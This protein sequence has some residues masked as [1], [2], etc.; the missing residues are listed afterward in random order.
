M[1]IILPNYAIYAINQ[2]VII[3]HNGQEMKWTTSPFSKSNFEDDRAMFTHINEYWASLNKARQ[4]K[5]FG[6]YLKIF[7]IFDS[8]DLLD[9]IDNLISE[10]V[11]QLFAEHTLDEIRPWV[12][13][14]SGIIFPK[15]PELPLNFVGSV[16]KNHTREKTYTVSDYVDLICMI[17]QLRIMVPIWGKYIAR[18][19]KINGTRFKEFYAF[20]LL[21][22]SVFYHEPPVQKLYN[23]IVSVLPAEGSK[24]DILEGISS[25]E[26]PLWNLSLLIV[27]KLCLSDIRG[28]D[29][30]PIIIRHISRHIME[31]A[32]R[33]DNGIDDGIKEKKSTTD[34]NQ[35]EENQISIL[36]EYKIKEDITRGEVEYIASC[37][38][39]AYKMAR[40]IYPGVTDDEVNLAMSNMDL[41]IKA[42]AE[43]AQTMLLMWTIDPV[44]PSEAVNFL[45]KIDRTRCL[46]A[47][48]AA[49]WAKGFHLFSALAT[50]T[51]ANT[52]GEIVISGTDSKGRISKETNEMLEKLFPFSK[53][54]RGSKS[55]RAELV[56]IDDFIRVFTLRSWVLNLTDEQISVL[57]PG[58][59]S[60]KR[61]IIPHNFKEQVAQFVIDIA[62]RNK[63]KA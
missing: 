4:D 7:D 31:K 16:D 53:K 41:L 45:N 21:E 40:L 46:C 34:G 23:Y 37:V 26:F 6:I 12:Q 11:E 39:D 57:Y 5:I 8:T 3:E 30:T 10:Q 29:P 20:K 17:L 25:E 38:Q 58:Y 14:H 36:E 28:L 50:A 33:I 59:A 56:A 42:P 35:S 43:E 19:S 22:H 13:I 51:A 47:I 60:Q 48:S 15:P 52:E 32:R 54:Q 55:N 18:T 27:R 63:L 62:S 44:I 49:Y 9:E 1:Q 24:A 2:E 61:L